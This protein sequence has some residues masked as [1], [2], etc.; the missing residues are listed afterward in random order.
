M[1]VR[2]AFAAPVIPPETGA[3]IR[4][5]C[6]ALQSEQ[7]R[8]SW[9]SELAATAA[10]S[11]LAVGGSIVEESINSAGRTP[12]AQQQQLWQWRREL[13]GKLQW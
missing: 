11:S 9:C 8:A 7:G 4:L 6:A 13:Q 2:V 3:S 5:G 10:S 1:K 12:P